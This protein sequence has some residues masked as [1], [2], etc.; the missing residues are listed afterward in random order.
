MEAKGGHGEAKGRPMEPKRVPKGCQ[1]EAKRGQGDAKRRPREAK[2]EPKKVKAEK[3]FSPAPNPYHFG[4]QNPTT[5]EPDSL[6]NC[7]ETML[8]ISMFL[9]CFRFPKHSQN[10]PQNHPQIIK[11][12]MKKET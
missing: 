11:N 5:F 1:G 2:G 8:S 7:F 9:N 3:E 4:T 12:Q 6:K 10:P